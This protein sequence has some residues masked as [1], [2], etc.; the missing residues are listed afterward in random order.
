[1]GRLECHPDG[2]GFVI[3]ENSSLKEDIFVPPKKIGNALHG[4][5][6]LVRLARQRAI[7]SR[8]RKSSSHGEIIEVV[9]R[10]CGS[11]LGKVFRHQKK[12]Y[13]SPLDARY[14]NVVQVV[15]EGKKVV[16]GQIVSVAITVQPRRNQ[17]PLGKISE[18]LGDPDDP[19]I[20][21]KIVCHD[22]QIPMEFSREIL[23][24]ATQAQ[25]LEESDLEKRCDLRKLPTVTIDGETARDFDDAVSIERLKDGRF[26]LWVHIADVSH[27]VGKETKLDL[28]AMTRGTSVYFPDRAIPMLP[29]E[30]SN[31]LCSLQ[32]DVDRLTL[33]VALEVGSGGEILKS[34]FCRSVIHS[35]AQLT[36]ETV[37]KILIVKDHQLR[38]H[39]SQLLEI[40]GWMLD[41]CRLLKVNRVRRGAI[42]FDLP[43]PKIDYGVDGGVLDIVRAERNEAHRIIE[44]FMLLANEAVAQHLERQG[45]PLIYR[46]HE[47]PDT[48]KVEQFNFVANKFGYSLQPDQ[49]GEYSSRAFQELMQKVAGSPE[50]KFLSYRMLRSFRQARYSEANLGHFGLATDCYTHF[51]SPIRRYPDLVVHRLL[52]KVIDSEHTN[53]ESQQLF[54]QLSQVAVHSTERELAAVQAERKIMRWLIAEFMKTRLGDEFEACVNGFRHNGFFVELVEHFVEGFV[55]IETLRDDFYQFNERRQCFIGEKTKRVFRIGDRLK[56]RVDKVN[57]YSHLIEFSSP[58]DR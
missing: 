45:V 7:H 25:Q 23:R 36:Y 2:Y 10:G 27:Y 57:H 33:T 48:R 28:E 32:P 58:A 38:Q 44:E 22:H 8:K 53:R 47:T 26:K 4:D 15:E 29:E 34:D 55:S 50:E 41:L 13:V 18:V 37:K 24:E 1:M 9:K 40:L 39:H 52:K 54:S 31:K 46:V 56:V 6:V 17:L 5:T 19:E 12:T 21:Y 14:H 16:E 49:R 11:I 42:D 30:L 51:T 43:E 3:L 35:D 20:Q